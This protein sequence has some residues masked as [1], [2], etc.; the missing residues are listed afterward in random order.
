M[1]RVKAAPAVPR[2]WTV[3]D[4]PLSDRKGEVIGSI[5]LF[6]LDD[7]SCALYHASM[8]WIAECPNYGAALLLACALPL[9][10]FIRLEFTRSEYVT[11]LGASQDFMLR[12][13]AT[14]VREKEMTHGNPK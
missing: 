4:T 13:Y 10:E 3:E 11:L 5:L 6:T 1:R 14:L 9:S 12:H 8:G 2:V 7:G